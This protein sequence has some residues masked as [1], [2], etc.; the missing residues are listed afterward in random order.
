METI[1]RITTTA[2]IVYD[3]YLQFSEQP[4]I[5]KSI[6]Q[7]YMDLKSIAVQNLYIQWPLIFNFTD[8]I[9]ELWIYTKFVLSFTNSKNVLVLIVLTE[10]FLAPN[11]T[12]LSVMVG[13]LL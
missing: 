13:L 3:C 6:E 1:V 2:L 8:K 10:I 7:S 9:L 12:K 4:N 11:L 5:V